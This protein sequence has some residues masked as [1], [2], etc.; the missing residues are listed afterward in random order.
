MVSA[1]PKILIVEDEPAQMELLSYNLGERGLSDRARNGWE[2]ALLL[3]EEESP[4]LVLLDWMLPNV[5]GIEICRQLKNHSSMKSVP[6][7]MLT[8]RGEEADLV[9]GLETGAD[10]YMSKPYSVVEL[11]GPFARLI[12]PRQAIKCWRHDAIWGYYH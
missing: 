10:D 3:A 11:N 9:R 7:M 2:E 6:I 5:S 12:T 4:D 8:A 1:A